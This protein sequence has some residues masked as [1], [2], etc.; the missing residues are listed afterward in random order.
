[1]E[2]SSSSPGGVSPGETLEHVTDAS[3]CAAGGGWYYDDAMAPTEI[4][5]CPARCTQIQD[6][7][8]ARVQ[9]E[10]G[11]MTDVG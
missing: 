8:S 6:D 10:L 11:C 2:G 9:L 4:I 3:A 7:V 5:L 1:L